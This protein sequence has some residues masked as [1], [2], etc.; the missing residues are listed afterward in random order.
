[1]A[2]KYLLIER[3]ER[4]VKL[5]L[6]RPRVQNVLHAP[7]L[8]ELKAALK[9]LGHDEARAVVLLAGRGKAFSVGV[10][11]DDHRAQEMLAEVMAGVEALEKPVIAVVHGL[12]LGA[13]LE[14]AL[15]CDFIIAAEQAF[16]A[17]DSASSGRLPAGGLSQKLPRLIGSFKAKEVLLA[18]QPLSA[19]EAHSLGLVNEVVAEE[20]LEAASLDLAQRL[21][22]LDQK[23]LGRLKLLI[24]Q[25]LKLDMERALL[26]ER[27][28]SL[29]S[30]HQLE[31][32]ALYHHH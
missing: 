13:G 30:R 21:L 28:E 15:A 26:L 10:A 3:G 27:I 12:A 25:G 9:E 19:L 24:N 7:L 31:G 8:R 6:N 22:S 17:D 11:K 16:F 1:M 18:G 5:V 20:G 23:V 14:L 29:H 32:P 4:L 2:Y